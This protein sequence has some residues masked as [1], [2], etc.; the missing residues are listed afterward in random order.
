PQTDEFLGLPVI[1]DSGDPTRTSQTA[2]TLLESPEAARAPATPLGAGWS[3]Q[4][5]PG[6]ADLQPEGESN[7]LAVTARADSSETAV[8]L[9]N[10]FTAETVRAGN[11][12]GRGD[13]GARMG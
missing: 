7:I 9:A 12:C 8:N 11:A 10:T 4:K 6:A 2:A 5:V 1:R 3:E 13:A